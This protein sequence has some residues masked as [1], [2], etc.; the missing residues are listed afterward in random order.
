[1]HL[2][3]RWRYVR[4]FAR[5]ARCDKRRINLATASTLAHLPSTINL[6]SGTDFR[7]DCFNIDVQSSVNP[8][9]V[10]DITKLTWGAGV[11]TQRF[12]PFQWEKDRWDRILANDVLEHIPDLV[13]AMTICKDL[14]KPN[15]EMHINVPY[16]LSLGAWQDPTH[17]RA[18]NENSWLY[19]TDWHC[20]LGWHNRFDLTHPEYVLSDYGRSLRQDDDVRRTPRAV[21]A[22]RVI[23][24]KR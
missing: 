11:R 24:K 2:I 14:L 9:L 12:A 16:D 13:A 10:L 21:V 15:G 8:D 1:M 6:G 7:A 19:Y 20:Y 4:R 5:A 22:M 3:C 18:F 23:L 17:V